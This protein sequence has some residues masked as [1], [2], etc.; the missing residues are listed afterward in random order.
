MFF[1]S[2]RAQASTLSSNP[3]V[4]GS[5]C[6]QRSPSTRR[7]RVIPRRE[8]V[9][10]LPPGRWHRRAPSSAAPA[11]PGLRTGRFGP[12]AS[13]CGAE[14]GRHGD[15]SGRGPGPRPRPP[16]P[17]ARKRPA[18]SGSRGEE[19][20]EEEDGGADDGEAEEEPEE[21]EEEEEDLID[22]FAIAS[23][24]SLEALQ[25]DASLQPP[26]RLEH[27]L[28]HS[29]KRKRGGSSGATGEPGDSSDREPGRPPGDRARKWP[30]K[31]RRKEASSRHSLEA[32]YICDAESDLDERVSDDDLDPSFT[33]STSK[34]SGPHGAF[35][36]NCEAK[37][38]VVPKVSGLERSQEQPPGPDPLL[39]PFPPKEPPPPPAPRPPVSPP[40]PLPATPSLP[41]PPQP[42][43]QLR[44]SP[45]GLRTSPYGN[46]LD[47]STGSSSRPPPKAPAPPVAQPPPSSSSSSSSSS[48]AS[49]SSA[50]LTHRPPTPSLPLPLSTHGFP[51]PGLRCQGTL[52][53]Q[54]LTPFLSRT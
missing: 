14:G 7:F 32:G 54:P 4:A 3:A 42:Q 29:G 47:L 43:L 16:R 31:R 1:S 8:A 34:A 50:Q 10:E 15:G 21:E 48:S 12:A 13:G 20:E 41:P 38:S 40:A 5:G 18:G 49:S 45:F 25:K 28:K 35:N 11:T 36:G 46:S 44:V 27:R 53:P 9:A 52:G 24:A 23:F 22:G 26:E 51:P 17:R 37:L 33:V 19:E 2:Q 6:T 39:V 30:N